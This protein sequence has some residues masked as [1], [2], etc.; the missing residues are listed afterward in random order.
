MA[1][2]I[3]ID[4][5]RVLELL[6]QNCCYDQLILEE[7][8][9]RSPDPIPNSDGT[10]DATPAAATEEKA[11][12]PVVESVHC[13]GF[14]D[15]LNKFSST[16]MSNSLW[17]VCSTSAPFY[18]LKSTSALTREFGVSETANGHL[19]SLTME[20]G[21]DKELLQSFVHSMVTPAAFH[22]ALQLHRVDGIPVKKYSVH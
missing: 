11:S 21:N 18:V 13:A 4:V 12:I 8:F 9:N 16:E 10:Q 20:C 7:E 1:I 15:R 22:Y 19:L 17:C 5:V 14:W 3:F 2:H 6:W